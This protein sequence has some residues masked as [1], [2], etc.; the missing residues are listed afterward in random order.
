MW[1]MNFVGG[2]SESGVVLCEGKGEK[3]L[4]RCVVD[5]RLPRSKL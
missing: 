5:L 1:R 3:E 2:Q 4:M